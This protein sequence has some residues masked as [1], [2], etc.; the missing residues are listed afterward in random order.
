MNWLVV[1]MPLTCLIVALATTTERVRLMTWIVHPSLYNPAHLAE[2]VA[3]ADVASRGRFILGVGPGFNHAV[4][5]LAV[6]ISNRV[7]VV[8]CL[9]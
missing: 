1:A 2:M 5:S 6:P 7:Q 3:L 9:S 8:L 4:G